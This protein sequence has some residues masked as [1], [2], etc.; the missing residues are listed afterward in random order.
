ML[1]RAHLRNV[2]ARPDV[3]V[4]PDIFIL[5]EKMKIALPAHEKFSYVSVLDAVCPAR[6]CPLALDGGIP[7]AW[8]HAHL[9]AEGSVYV[10][11]RIAKL[12]GLKAVLA[13]ASPR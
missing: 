3:F 9:T 2:D 13:E 10:A 5:D 7:L 8:D 6:Q 1:M 12:P 11:A 4:L